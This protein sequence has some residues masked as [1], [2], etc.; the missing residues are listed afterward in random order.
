MPIFC[1]MSRIV[2]DEVCLEGCGNFI[3]MDVASSVTRIGLCIVKGC[4]GS[5]RFEDVNVDPSVTTCNI[6]EE[7]ANDL[8][9]TVGMCLLA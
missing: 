2:T 7:G 1:P 8:C 5:A 4:D 9:M 6:V 3:P